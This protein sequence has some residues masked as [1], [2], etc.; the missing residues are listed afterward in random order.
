M[1]TSSTTTTCPPTTRCVPDRA[2]PAALVWLS[3]AIV[4]GGGWWLHTIHAL[5]GATEEGAPSDVT[6]WLRDSTLALPI[7]FLGVWLGLRVVR[8][9]LRPF[10]GDDLG[11]LR[12]MAV[13]A[14]VG[15]VTS[16]VVALASP[17]HALMFQAEHHHLHAGMAMPAHMALEGVLAGWSPVSS[18]R[19][20]LSSHSGGAC[21]PTA[22]RRSAPGFRRSG[23]DASSGWRSPER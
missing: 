4:Y 21:G 14:L 9:L 18:S 15:I 1:D 11:V 13:V 7:V 16:I 19:R 8:E 2:R 10:D 17:V 12:P 5:Q 22:R 6:H 23:R 3:L 20:R